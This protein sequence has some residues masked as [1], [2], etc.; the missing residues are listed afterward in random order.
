MVRW[1]RVPEPGGCLSHDHGRTTTHAN[2][3]PDPGSLVT[4][5]QKAGF[6]RPPFLVAFGLILAVFDPLQRVARAF[7]GRRPHEVVVG[8]LQSSL[9]PALR[10][11][12][13]R[14]A[15]ER[16]PAVRGPNALP[17]HREPP[18][19][20]RRS[21]RRQLPLSQSFQSTSPPGSWRGRNAR[22]H[23]VQPA[24]RRER[25]DGPA[26]NRAQALPAMRGWAARRRS[27]AFPW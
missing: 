11:C 23:L 17:A 2:R 10:I 18:V 21:D 13:T 1:W 14:F 20:V 12:G 19:R 16:D 22:E 7:G 9:T 15:V 27:A 26:A 25:G 5:R 3:I 8:L 24:L 6:S 4:Y